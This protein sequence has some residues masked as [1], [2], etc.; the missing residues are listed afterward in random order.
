LSYLTNIIFE[1]HSPGKGA[2]RRTEVFD[3]TRTN[4]R[5][6]VQ[7]D[8]EG[9]SW[10]LHDNVAILYPPSKG[11]VSRGIMQTAGGGFDW[12]LDPITFEDSDPQLAGDVQ[13]TGERFQKEGRWFLLITSSYG[14]KSRS[15]I[16]RMVKKRI[17]IFF[18]PFFKTA[19][20]RKALDQ[21]V[22]V[23]FEWVLEPDTC[24]VLVSRGYRSDGQLI[25]ET[26]GWQVWT[27]LPP[28]DYAVP[29]DIARITPKSRDEAKRLD[30]QIPPDE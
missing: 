10:A 17:P 30:S 25:F 22:P 20:L 5:P 28:Q 27:N 12:C 15:K 6:H 16:T 24:T 13:V 9:G 1:L 18:R 21:V 11:K 14:E 19:E 8:N 7:V 4:S 29:K 3:G 23:H 26:Q 2:L